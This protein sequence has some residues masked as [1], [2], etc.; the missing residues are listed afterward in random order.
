M[1]LFGVPIIVAISLLGLLLLRRFVMAD[2][3]AGCCTE[4][5]VMPGHV[6]CHTT[7]RGAFQTSLRLRQTGGGTQCEQSKQSG[8]HD[9]THK[10][11]FRV[12]I[13][14]NGERTLG[15]PAGSPAAADLPYLKI[16]L[17]SRWLEERLNEFRS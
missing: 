10:I 16:V 8:D 9:G 3:A 13:Q 17:V 5:A 11:S 15:A 1:R 4:S 7:H 6:S 2:G 14:R 12:S